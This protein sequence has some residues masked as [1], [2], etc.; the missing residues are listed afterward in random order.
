[1]ISSPL[2][3]TFSSILLRDQCLQKKDK[4]LIACSGGSDSIA[5]FHL[6]HSLNPVWKFKIGLLHFNHGLRGKSA[7]AD[8]RFV[9]KMGKKFKVSIYLGKGNVLK[10]AKKDKASI[11]EAARKLRYQFFIQTAKRYGY[12]KVL[13]AHHQN[14]Q[15]ETV[16]MRILQGTGIRGLCG[17]RKNM[18][19]DGILFYRPLLKIKKQ[20]IERYLKAQKISFR[21]DQSNESTQFLRNKIRHKLLPYLEKNLNPRTLDALCRIP[22][23]LNEEVKAL[24]VFQSQAW[25]ECVAQKNSRKVLF[26]AKNYF[27]FPSAIQFQMLNRGLQTLDAQSG[28]SFEAWQRIQEGIKKKSGRWTLPKKID[29]SLQN[30]HFV[31]SRSLQTK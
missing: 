20:E 17:I 30:D 19:R 26:K 21:T 27:S 10:E 11:E 15:A 3:P 9:Q 8:M 25:K 4:I 28:L 1:M 2:L 23:A 14:D 16:L 22:E 29:L 7:N 5:L 31:L 13:L 18:R 6:L 24:E 12:K